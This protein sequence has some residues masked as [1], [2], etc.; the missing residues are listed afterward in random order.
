MVTARTATSLHRR[1]N[2]DP[3]GYTS[4]DSD[5]SCHYHSGYRSY[6][7]RW[8]EIQTTVPTGETKTTRSHTIRHD[9]PTRVRT[10]RPCEQEEPIGRKDIKLQDTKCPERTRE[11]HE[12]SAS[13]ILACH[14]V[15]TRRGSNDSANLQVVRRLSKHGLRKASPVHRTSSSP[16]R[17]SHGSVVLPTHQ[18]AAELY[19]RRSHG[20]TPSSPTG[21]QQ[22]ITIPSESGCGYLKIVSVRGGSWVRVRRISVRAHGL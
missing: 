17:N 11:E 1:S 12:M 22:R 13:L 2:G 8:T 14:V 15:S 16:R 10:S 3:T 19:L 20:L 7:R 4:L 21:L 18:S 9:C 6:I 5:R